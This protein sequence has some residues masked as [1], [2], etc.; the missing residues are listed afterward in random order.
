MMSQ[1]M[2]PYK[3]VNAQPWYLGA[4]QVCDAVTGALLAGVGHNQ[5]RAWAFPLHTP[6]GLNVLQ[7]YAFDHAFHNGLFVGQGNVSLSGGELTQFWAPEPDWRGG[8]NIIF[9]HIGQLRYGAAPKCAISADGVSFTYQSVW[10]DENGAPMFDE[11]RIFRVW[12]IEDAVLC[13]LT[14][15]KQATYGPLEFRKTKHGSICAR[16]QTQLLPAL[17]GQIL[18]GRGEEIQRGHADE[19]AMDM[20]CDFVAYENDV[21]GLGRFG[22]CL[23][24]R[25][26]N[27]SPERNAPWFVRD[28]G[29]TFFNPTMHQGI[30]LSQGEEWSATLR[31]VAYD[32]A[33]T[34]QRVASWS[35]TA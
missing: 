9:Q 13:E 23:L 5:H 27:A 34:L 24:I 2:N 22:L 10:K 3:V 15:R 33:L 29:V 30:S 1:G 32:G 26:N 19:V 21:P 20:P 16:V 14:S 6:H 17:G 25:D 11:E 8:D 31:A 35:A 12:A 7:E 28:Y 4:N 18:A